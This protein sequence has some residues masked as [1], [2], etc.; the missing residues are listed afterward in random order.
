MS[1]HKPWGRIKE[2]RHTEKAE[3]KTLGIYRD[4]KTGTEQGSGISDLWQGDAGQKLR[5]QP[6]QTDVEKGPSVERPV[7]PGLQVAYPLP[8]WERSRWSEAPA[9]M[10]VAHLLNVHLEHPSGT[11][12]RLPAPYSFRVT[13]G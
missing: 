4:G 2:G 11:G 5:S 3:S 1:M 10:A 12:S 9:S 7:H 13:A 6:P 8:A